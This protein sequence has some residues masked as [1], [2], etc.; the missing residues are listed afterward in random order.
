MNLL[1]K[2][3]GAQFNLRQIVSGRMFALRHGCSASCKAPVATVPRRVLIVMAGMIGDTVMSTPVLIELRRLFPDA[4]LTVLGQRHNREL[5]AD[6]PLIDSFKTVSAD[7]FSIRRRKEVL[8]LQRWLIGENFDMAILALGDQFAQLLAK[9]EIP[10]CVGV[11]GHPLE[12]CLTHLYDIKSPRI[13]GPSE[14]LNALR[15]LGL[16]VRD[17]APQLWVSESSRRDALSKLSALG[18]ERETPYVAIHP[19]GSTPRQKWKM[20]HAREL[21]NALSSE[22]H[23]KSVLIGGSETPGGGAQISL[24]WVVSIRPGV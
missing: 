6:C 22:L 17:V 5:L 8:E 18:L 13:W 10:I 14:R 20:E 2:L 15:C 24:T 21:S 12:P 9:A 4:H 11:K 3:Y 16:D 1:T 23:V 7:P 19:F